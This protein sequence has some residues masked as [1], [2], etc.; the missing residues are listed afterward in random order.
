MKPKFIDFHCHSALKPYSKSFRRKYTTYENSDDHE[1]ESSIW[2]QDPP[3]DGD[4]LLNT[5]LTLT[6][7][8]QADFKTSLEGGVRVMMVS[9]DPMEI[10]FAFNKLRRPMKFTGRIFQNL[11]SG[12]GHPRL[13]N[14][15][16]IDDYYQDLY[17]NYKFMMQL[18]D[19]YVDI[20]G[21]KFKYKL[22]DVHGD[23]DDS[24]IDTIFIVLTI[25]GSH[26]FNTGLE[27]AN[28]ITDAG[29]VI[30]NVKR[31]K[32]SNEWAIKPF[33]VSLAH[34]FPNLICGQA[35]SF[36]FPANLTYDQKHDKNE[37][38]SVMGEAVI[39]ELLRN[40]NGKRIFIDLKHMNIKS[41]QRYYQILETK[42]QGEEI[43]LIVSHGAMKFADIPNKNT[44]EIN[45]YNEEIVRIANSNGIFGIQLDGR[46]LKKRI[47]R[48][49]KKIIGKLPSRKLFRKAGFVWR[50]IEEMAMLLYEDKKFKGDPWGFQV[51][52]SDYDGVIDPLNGYWTH[53]EMGLL[54]TNLVRHAEAFLKTSKA[55]KLPNYN[56]L[57]AKDIV[58]KLAFENANNFLIKHLK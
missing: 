18:N 2:H 20:D 15:Q 32:D 49:R 35:E 23:I 3:N 40:D 17:R 16:V 51:I 12:I 53:K 37:T 14:L 30:Q 1:D 19:T 45:F 25:E 9:I 33:F 38:I 27:L 41:R 56:S 28:V 13:K 39:D 57:N 48:N 54:Y 36:G 24:A 11:V 5:A 44:S 22:V 52:G 4:I 58:D 26:V 46:R 10:G 21:K 42:Y 31:L 55:K 29:K 47:P 34:H 7:F 6:K 8:R 43:P 50:Q